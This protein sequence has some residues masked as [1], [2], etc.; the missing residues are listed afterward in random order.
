MIHL[1]LFSGIGGF[2]LATEKVWP[3]V[4]HVFC[5]ID[6]FCQ[7]VLKKH[8][9]KS[10]IYGDIRTVTNA[11]HR[12][13]AKQKKSSAGN[14]Q[15]SGNID[16]LTGGFPCQPFSQ[17]GQ[18]RG[19]DDERYLWPEMLRV[20]QEFR[21]TWIIGENVAGIVNMALEQVCSD[22][23]GQGYEV[24]PF[25]IPACAIGAPH[26]RDRVWIIG[27]SQNVADTNR[28]RGGERA[29]KRASEGERCRPQRCHAW[30][31]WERNWQ[32]VAF[33]TCNVGVDDGISKRLARF[34]DGSTITEAKW[35]QQALKGY[36]NSIV[37]QVAI[38]IMKIIDKT[39]N[40]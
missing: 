31:D 14:K 6:P 10:K 35:R 29:Q 19:K 21:P 4:E 39:W 2:A 28:Q 5:E 18:Q 37:P 1:D 32:E 40:N 27:H 17:A 7:Q 30:P 15:R 13:S 22:L 12:G 25:I 36:G 34:P 24:Q 16:L 26:R 23:E 33:T 38:E 9:P 3:E 11:N 20:I 8:W